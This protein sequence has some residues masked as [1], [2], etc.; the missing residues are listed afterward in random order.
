MEFAQVL[1][2]GP[3][4]TRLRLVA[5]KET[6]VRT[7]VVSTQANVPAP[8]VRVTGYNGAAILGTLDMAGPTVLPVV[9]GSVMP[10][11]VRYSEAQSFNAELPSTWVRGGLSVRIEV[12]PLRVLGAPIVTDITPPLG[13]GTRIEVVLVPLVSGAY[14]PAVPSTA[15]VLDEITRRFPIPRANIAVTARPAYTLASVTDGLDTT[16]EWQTALTELNQLRTMESAPANRIYYGFVRRSGGGVAGIG[17]VPGRAALGWDDGTQWSRTMSHELGHNLSRPHAPCGNPASPDPSYPYPN[18]AMSATPLMDSVPAAIDIVSPLG[19]ADIMGYCNGLWFSDYNY[20]EIQRYM[21]GQPALV[22]AQVATD[23]TE[24]DLL[25]ISGTIGLDGLQLEAVQAMRAIASPGAGNYTLRLT[26]R[27]GRTIEQAFDAELVD[28]AVPP[29][30]QFAVAVPD[31][32]VALARIDVLHAG[33]AVQLRSAGLARAQGAG[34]ASIGLLRGIDW[35]ESNGV[36]RVTWDVAAA[37]HVAATYVG[38]EV[39]TVLGVNRVGGVADFDTS[40][41]PAGGR[42]EIALSDG[43]NARTLQIRR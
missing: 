3:S 39:R 16:T 24:Q 14:V 6:W 26:T 38:S 32:G 40:Q 8:L 11:S 12:D 15:A 30:R 29:E 9:S 20:R 42:F 34:G 25:L 23:A 33:S 22:A 28:H 21:E 1:S 18:G 5:G 4:D 31:P 13:S 37:S 10:D 7:Y 19:T 41:L 36:L 43:L 27:D 17:F 2:Q 35:T